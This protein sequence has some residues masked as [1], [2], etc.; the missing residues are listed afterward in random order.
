MR[1][2]TYT[3]RDALGLHARP[4]GMLVKEASRYQSKITVSANGKQAEAD[5]LMLLMGMGIR[6]GTQVT[7][8]AEGVDEDS[9]EAG[10]RHFFEE[11]L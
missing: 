7:V 1:S 11:S 5:R 6:Q 8:T 9:A 2:F 4:A 10:I 3:V